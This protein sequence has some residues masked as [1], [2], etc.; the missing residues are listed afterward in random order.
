ML[1]HHR[2][3]PRVTLVWAAVA[4]A[5][6]LWHPD[7]GGLV[8][9]ASTSLHNLAEHPVLSM[10]L[11]VFTLADGWGEWAT[12]VGLSVVWVFAEVNLGWRRSLAAFVTGHLVATLA[13]ALIEAT[14]VLTGL[15]SVTIVCIPDDVGASYGFLALAGAG[16]AIGLRRSRWCLL[17]APALVAISVVDVNGWTIAGHAVAISVGAVL[18]TWCRALDHPAATP[19]DQPELVATGAAGPR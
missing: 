5:L 13:V 8:H 14:A 4:A 3:I 12:W 6:L 18:A 16:L 1:R 9:V 11:S 19:V 17:A 7:L 2:L 15:A 10:C